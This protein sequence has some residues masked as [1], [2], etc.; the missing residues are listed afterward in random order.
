MNK[1]RKALVIG[2]SKYLV[3][4]LKN[5]LNDAKAMAEILDDKGF[6]VTLKFDLDS[7]EFFDAIRGF[8][9]SIS[10]NTDTIL[11]YFAGHG[12]EVGGVNYLIPNDFG[13]NSNL[14][15]EAPTLDHIFEAFSK[16]S[17]AASRIYI[18]D[19]CRND[20]SQ[21][22]LDLITSKNIISQ[23]TVNIGQTKPTVT[24]DNHF[25][26]FAT[27]PGMTASDGGTSG[28]NGLYTECLIEAISRYGMLIEDTFKLVREKVIERN[29]Y[30]QIPWEHSSLRAYFS[31]DYYD[32][33]CNLIDTITLPFDMLLSSEI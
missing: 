29:G 6:D 31:F 16:A 10:K 21:Q 2:N 33:P 27:A 14:D 4:P 23:R 28:K 7:V 20:G 11:F 1:T 25:I 22:L 19:A 30:K 26:A 8:C 17:D 15:Y 12:V 3:R 5:P 13:A 24:G 9:S 18:L 32:V